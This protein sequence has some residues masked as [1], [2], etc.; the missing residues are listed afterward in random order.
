MLVFSPIQ[1]QLQQQEPK[2]Q[3]AALTSR[4]TAKSLT[5]SSASSVKVVREHYV[6]HPSR[7]YQLVTAYVIQE[8]RSVDAMIEWSLQEKG[9]K[10]HND[11]NV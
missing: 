5:P 10:T 9:Q 7:W 1:T 2:L 6:L 8:M 4:A 11:E 3:R